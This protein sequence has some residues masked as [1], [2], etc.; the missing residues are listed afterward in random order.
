MASLTVASAID[1]NQASPF[2]IE[3]FSDKHEAPP[4]S[5]ACERS[6]RLESPP[7]DALDRRIGSVTSRHRDI[8]LLVLQI[9]FSRSWRFR[10]RA[11]STRIA[12]ESDRMN[13]F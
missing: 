5:G 13:S 6:H 1:G 12:S 4:G 10:K 9:I 8:F 11:V 2:G 3:D 7:S